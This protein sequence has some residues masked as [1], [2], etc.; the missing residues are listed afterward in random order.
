MK[1]FS[2]FIIAVLMALFVSCSIQE[3]SIETPHSLEISLQNPVLATNADSTSIVKA[4]SAIQSSPEYIL[5]SYTRYKNG[6]F[7]VEITE[8][9]L[10]S[11][12]VSQEDYLN[13]VNVVSRMNG[14]K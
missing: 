4:K 8:E 12:G 11:L 2:V 14:Q 7:I 10:L 9:E 6:E 3:T 5:A 1:V 13:Y